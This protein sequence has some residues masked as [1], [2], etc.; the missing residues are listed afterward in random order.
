MPHNVTSVP[1]VFFVLIALKTTLPTSNARSETSAIIVE[2]CSYKIHKLLQK[3]KYQV[4]QLFPIT[5]CLL[6]FMFVYF[7]LIFVQK[8]LYEPLA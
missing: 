1:L 7:N 4:K 8:I 6:D 5:Y 3:L 2:N